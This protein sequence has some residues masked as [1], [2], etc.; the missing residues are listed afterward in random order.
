MKPQSISKLKVFVLFLTMSLVFSACSSNDND[1]PS[2]EDVIATE[3]LELPTDLLGDYQGA[4]FNELVDGL[5]SDPNA[6]A[7]SV[8]L[9]VTIE[10]T[11][12]NIYRINFSDG[13]E[14]ITGLSFILLPSFNIYLSSN[15]DFSVG[16]SITNEQ[17]LININHK[18]SDEPP[19][20]IGS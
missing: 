19:F 1:D 8:S 10:E 17:R 11:S 9:T 14:S 12:S 5:A 15:T 4:L 16:L 2:D 20:F 18:D 3:G 7:S 6:P 13:R